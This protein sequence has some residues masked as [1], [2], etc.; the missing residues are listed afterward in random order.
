MVSRDTKLDLAAGPGGFLARAL[1]LWEPER[2]FGQVQNQ[3]YGYLFPMGPF[4]AVGRRARAAGWVTQ[5]LVARLLVC[6]RSPG[7]T[8]W[9]ASSASAVAADPDGRPALAF[10]LTPRLLTGLGPI[11]VESLPMCLAPWVLVPL[12]AASR[13]GSERRAALLSAL[14][15][16]CRAG[17]T[18]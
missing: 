4:F 10:A 16:L 12:V 17:S 14:V 13:D 5:R 8:S 7:R 9:P 11:S 18:R 6:S 1:H 2:T 15:V 3:A